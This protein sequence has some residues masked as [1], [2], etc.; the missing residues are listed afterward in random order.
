MR[1]ARYNIDSLPSPRFD[2][3]RKPTRLAIRRARKCGARESVRQEGRS[4]STPGEPSWWINECPA[5]GQLEGRRA[6]SS[7][8]DITIQ[9]CVPAPMEPD[10]IVRG[11]EAAPNAPRKRGTICHRV[12]SSRLAGSRGTGHYSGSSVMVRAG[13]ENPEHHAANSG[14]GAGTAVPPR[15][16]SRSGRGHRRFEYD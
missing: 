13:H 10:P 8:D 15:I 5:N 9:A 2:S 16:H 14:M 7:E 3:Y 11:R 1:P 4:Y 12:R 6:P